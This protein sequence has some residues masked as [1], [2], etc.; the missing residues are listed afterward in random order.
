M[1]VK[2]KTKQ[3]LESDL[4]ME[5][6]SDLLNQLEI[7]GT[8]ARYYTDLVDDY[9]GLWVTKCL[10]LDDI[11]KRGVMVKYNNGGGQTGYKKNDSVEQLIK[12][13]GQML[14]L[15]SELGIKWNSIANAQPRDPGGESIDE[16]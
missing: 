10:L 13:S 1:A 9:M 15:L 11:Q 4:F 8:T 6:R 7:A 3:Y 14:K 16:L 2:K 12:V 5:I